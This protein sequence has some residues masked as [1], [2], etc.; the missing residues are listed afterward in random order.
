MTLRRRLV[1]TAMIFAWPAHGAFAANVPAALVGEWLV[2]PQYPQGVYTSDFG[3]ANADA[4]RLLLNKDGTYVFS[5]F[6]SFQSLQGFGMSGYQITCQS[7]SVTVERGT[8]QVSGG[9]ITFKTSKV[10]KKLGYSPDRLNNGC[11]RQGASLTSKAVSETAT[12]TWSIAKGELTFKTK[13]GSATYVRRTPE[14]PAPPSPE[15]T[16]LRPELR[17]EW[18]SGRLSPIEYYNTATGKWAE[19]S[20]TSVILKLRDDLSY[21]RTGLLVVTTYG[22]TSKLL[23]QEKGKVTQN[24]SMLTFT[25]TTS[26]AVGY[27]C[28]PSKTSTQK[29]HVKPYTERALVKIESN[30]QHV[31]SLT[32]GSG[33]TLFNRPLGTPPESKPGANTGTMTPPPPSAGSSPT[34]SFDTPNSTAPTKPSPTPAKWT[35]TGAWDAVITVGTRTFKVRLDLYDDSPRILGG[36]GESVEYANGNSETGALDIGLEVDDRT[37]ELKVQGRFDGDRYTGSVRWTNYEGED[38]GRGTL[39]MTRR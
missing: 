36:G 1:L 31:L 6:E 21:E 26:S 27:T 24:G 3:G 4:R 35:A 7:M 11:R 9:N 5:E 19:A 20:G 18:H 15:A 33:E 38:L 25:P 37:M 13:E 10:D 30:G 34:A 14:K 16:R 29:N 28:T 8:Y 23:V 2:G 12:M 39:T 32:S 17:G 22:C